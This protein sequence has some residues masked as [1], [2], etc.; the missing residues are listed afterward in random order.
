MASYR[1]KFKRTFKRSKTN[2]SALKA[3]F[4]QKR[5]MK[6]YKK[7]KF[8][9]FKKTQTRLL[10]KGKDTHLVKQIIHDMDFIIADTPETTYFD[11][12]MPSQVA[13]PPTTLDAHSASVA[14]DGSSYLVQALRTAE[15]EYH[16]TKHRYYKVAKV[17]FAFTPPR[18]PQWKAGDGDGN[19]AYQGQLVIIR[20][21]KD[22]QLWTWLKNSVSFADMQ[23]FL[24]VIREH[25]DVTVRRCDRPF[26]IVLKPSH[27]GPFTDPTAPTTGEPAPDGVSSGSPAGIFRGSV[28]P[29]W[30]SIPTKGVFYQSNSG[31]QLLNPNWDLTIWRGLAF[32]YIPP[33]TIAPSNADDPAIYGT[34]GK[35]TIKTYTVYKGTDFIF[36]V[37]DTNPGLLS[38]KRQFRMQQDLPHSPSTPDLE[39][40]GLDSDPEDDEEPKFAPALEALAKPKPV[41]LKRLKTGVMLPVS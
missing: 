20:L 39:D 17:V 8:Q 25:P 15:F 4:K 34:I 33:T 3:A 19:Y 31:T 27:W 32:A 13:I 41:A 24:S 16:A 22:P 30:A 37:N 14:L 18:F 12:A 26:K 35:M 9:R 38:A 36:D 7:Q 2:K 40:L 11:F 29:S 10:Q 28:K 23:R 6:K 21:N 5:A 1:K